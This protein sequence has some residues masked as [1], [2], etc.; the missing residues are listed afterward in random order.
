M[1][2]ETPIEHGEPLLAGGTVRLFGRKFGGLTLGPEAT[3]PAQ[4]HARAHPMLARIYGFSY[5]GNYFKLS[6]P[7]VLLVYGAGTPVPADMNGASIDQIGIEFK[8][9]FFSESVSVWNA[10]D[11]D[12]SVR[13]DISSGWLSDLLIVPEASE[14]SNVTGTG[15]GT[16]EGRNRVVGRAV[17]AARAVMVGR[18]PNT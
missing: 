15:D 18:P 14:A 16:T 5:Q 7:T 10:L 4:F 11:V 6:V 9:E 12:F 2:D 3:L 17:M 8:D 1:S 13:I